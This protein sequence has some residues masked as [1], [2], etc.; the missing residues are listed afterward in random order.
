[1]KILIAG[2][3]KVGELL[4]RQLSAEGY[5]ITVIDKDKAALADE[6]EN[7]DVITYT[8]N[9]AAAATL[10]GAGVAGADLLIAATGS[11]EINLLCCMTAK[12]LNPKIH[13]IA[14][15]KSS[16]YHE[17]AYGMKDIFAIPLIFNPERQA[18][19]EIER[20]IRYPGFLKRDTFTKGRVEIVELKIDGASKLCG[21]ALSEIHSIV[22]SDVLVCA[23]LRDGVAIAPDGRFVLEASDRIF[24]TASADNLSGMLKSL[25]I[26][27]R[28]VNNVMIAGGGRL[29]R[30]LAT[31]LIR[32]RIGVKIIEKD[33]DTCLALSEKLPEA[34]IIHGD[35]SQQT[36]LNSEGIKS[37][38]AIVTLTGLD[39][40]NII[41]S[42]YA[43]T[44]GVPQV[45][46]KL[47]RLDS[48]DIINGLPLGSIISPRRL[49][50]ETI[51]Q[52][53]RAINNQ[54]GA[55]ASIHLIADGRAEA[56]E[57][58][59][60]KNTKNLGVPLKQLNLKKNVLVACIT[61]NGE[62]HIPNGESMIQADDT[63]VIVTVDET[64]LMQLNDIFD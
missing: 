49:S 25:G 39:E 55:A 53:V 12:S 15:L 63:V 32:R 23:V 20:L 52:Y 5:D 56:I 54:T 3:G 43:N 51:V 4:T 28:K 16:E 14:R 62:P 18:A 41:I 7:F 13:T 50:C 22:R 44:V 42:L 21:R 38:D 6:S 26:V 11:D 31:L 60:D 8:G 10:R 33:L 36:L 1:L 47:S 48:M 9:C 17:Q 35:A 57:F 40:L 29:S 2:N 61:R 45:I 64:K 27:T 37:C 59:A 19:V 58:V 30:Y 46:T 34:E 24:V